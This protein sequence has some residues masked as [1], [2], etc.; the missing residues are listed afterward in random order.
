MTFKH[1]LILC[2][3]ANTALIQ[4][5]VYG[6]SANGCGYNWSGCSSPNDC[7]CSSASGCSCSFASDRSSE[8]GCSCGSTSVWK[9]VA[10]RV[11]SGDR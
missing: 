3:G 10:M 11:S 9:N 5:I 2:L 6:W 7:G 1:C 8:I 4:V